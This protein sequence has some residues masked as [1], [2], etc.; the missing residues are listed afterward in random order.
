MNPTVLLAL[1][2]A[3]AVLL[4]SRKG[5]A[6]TPASDERGG[7][8][9]GIRDSVDLSYDPERAQEIVDEIMREHRSTPGSY[10]VRRFATADPEAAAE[11]IEDASS[12][13]DSQEN[14]IIAAWRQGRGSRQATEQQIRDY[15]R[16]L[17]LFVEDLTYIP[18]RDFREASAPEGV[19]TPDNVLAVQ[20]GLN[21]LETL[22]RNHARPFSSRLSAMTSSR[23]GLALHNTEGVG[24][25]LQEYKNLISRV[26]VSVLV[27]F[28][29]DRWSMYI[30]P[31]CF[32]ESALVPGAV[33]EAAGISSQD[34]IVNES[35]REINIRLYKVRPGPLLGQVVE[36]G[37]SGAC[38][39]HA[40]RIA[41]AMLAGVGRPD[42]AAKLTGVDPL[43]GQYVRPDPNAAISALS[44]GSTEKIALRNGLLFAAN[45]LRELNAIYKVNDDEQKG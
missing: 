8:I 18:Q 3:G 4:L 26:R 15:L 7:P 12:A 21:Q 29:N 34:V 19:L 14:Q 13:V 45:D 39:T 40:M 6:Q 20:R 37:Q 23:A 41:I 43:S 36:D 31:S 30:T 35:N 16:Q 22:L 5:G 17:R 11:P 27:P 33:M 9:G 44:G 38:T 42:L 25:E 2:G 28:S 24:G 32:D 10:A 1:A